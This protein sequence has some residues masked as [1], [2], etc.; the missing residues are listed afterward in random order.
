MQR[1]GFITLDLLV[2]TT[3]AG[4]LVIAGLP[5]FL[6]GRDRAKIT[7]VQANMHTIQLAAENFA[8]MAE[9]FYPGGI[10][11]TVEEVCPFPVNNKRCIAGANVRPFPPNA[12]I[13]LI[14]FKNP[15][16]P[17]DPAIANGFVA[18]LPSGCVYYCAYDQAGN[19]IGEGEA[20]WRYEIRGMGRYTPLVF[21][22]QGGG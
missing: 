12:L 15:F 2:A 8:T 17:S 14:G 20:G 4:I 9:G 3:M 7:E 10:R 6:S 22:L 11:T 18:K 5:K 1:Q 19:R 16:N 21:L 13:P